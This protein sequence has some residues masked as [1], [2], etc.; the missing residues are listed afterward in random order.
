M[1]SKL[2]AAARV[3]P[4]F[5]AP[6]SHQSNGQVENANRRVEHILRQMILDAKLGEPSRNNWSV[7]LPMCRSILNSKVVHRHGCT[8]NELLYGAT[9]ERSSI[10]EDEPWREDAPPSVV[11][12]HSDAASAAEVTIAQWRAQHE[13]LLARCESAQDEL[14]QKLAEMQGPEA[15]ELSS[16]VPGDAVLVS[17]EERP[18]HKLGARWL[19]PYLVVAEPEGQRVLLQHLSSK[20]VSE[21]ALNML[22]RCD[23]SLISDVNDWLPLAAADH[24]EYLV[25]SVEQHRPARRRLPSGKLR[26]KSDFDFLVRWEGLPDGEDNPSWEPW[27]NPESRWCT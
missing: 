20:K 7:L 24:F 5:V 17:A 26:P 12:S 1:M 14:V 21:F 13:T 15:A 8:A 6:Y 10:F 4:H 16:L 27:S 11:P 2:L 18:V 3:K 25:Q 23:L 22:K 19:G 9:S